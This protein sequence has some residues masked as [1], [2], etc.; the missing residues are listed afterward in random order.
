MG[1]QRRKAQL[2]KKQGQVG[3]YYEEEVD[4]NLLP[5][6]EEI[7]KLSEIDPNIMQW[8]KDRA[9]KEQDF[10]QKVF[11]EKLKLVKKN[12]RGSRWINYAGLLFSFLLLGGGMYSSY[13]LIMADHTLVGTLFTGVVLI[14]V[15]SMFLSKVK[16]NGNNGQPN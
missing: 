9:E 13:M 3:H 12:E 14:T 16:G 15:A 5:D 1:R 6:A 11:I 4:D 7:A 10:R 8:L 2:M